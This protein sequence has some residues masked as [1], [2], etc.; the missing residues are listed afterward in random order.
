MYSGKRIFH[1]LDTLIIHQRI[2]DHERVLFIHTIISIMQKLHS[3]AIRHL[4]D[5]KRLTHVNPL[6]LPEKT[7]HQIRVRQE[8]A[9]RTGQCAVF[10]S[11]L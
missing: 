4:I 3:P 11:D 8:R 6:H 9:I 5:E 7:C 10:F 1:I 2:T